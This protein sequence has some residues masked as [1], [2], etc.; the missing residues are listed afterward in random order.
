MSG[1]KI[2]IVG[3]SGF[4]GAS[5]ARYLSD[6]YEVRV[7]D[8]NPPPEDI[9]GKVDYALCDIVNYDDIRVL[10]ESIDLV[11]HAAVVQIPLINE[12]KRLGYSVNVTGI[13]NVCRAVDE[14]KSVKGMLLTGSWHVFGERDF[15]GT[16][17]EAFGWRPDKVEDRARLYALSKI[18]QETIVRIYDEMSSKLYGTVRIGTV[19]GEGMPEK[20]AA[21]I[22]ISKGLKGETITP[23]RHTMHRPMLYVHLIDVCRAFKA[24]AGIILENEVEKKE[25]SHEH[26]V[27]VFW[28]TPIT[29]LE[30]AEMVRHSIATHSSGKIL[31]EIR[32]VDTGENIMYSEDDKNRMSVD[33]SRAKQLLGIDDLN[34]P[35][36]AIESIVAAR[37]T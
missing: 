36:Q 37:I 5:L 26:V 27:N 16:V 18:A 14:T 20:T 32:V 35:K 17:N 2:A 9:Q 6:S 12:M 28:P 34:S 15:E 22:F 7:I 3:G 25:G 31:P 1:D 19:L 33:V 30:L 13:Q 8:K 24:F 4:V 29:I 23:F 21:S 10:M 11:I